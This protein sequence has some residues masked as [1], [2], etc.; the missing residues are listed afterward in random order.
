MI[1]KCNEHIDSN[2]II[3]GFFRIPVDQSHF[4][5]ELVEKNKEAEN[6]NEKRDYDPYQHRAV[7]H[8]TT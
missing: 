6:V 2:L 1:R 5:I 4:D 3:D 7:E 8:P